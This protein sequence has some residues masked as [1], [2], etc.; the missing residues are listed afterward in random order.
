MSVASFSGG[1]AL[2]L[3]VAGGVWFAKAQDNQISSGPD[4]AWALPDY[5]YYEW[6]H[7][8]PQS[9]FVSASLIGNDMAYPVNTWDIKCYHAENICH[10]ADVEEI[11]RDQLGG[12]TTNDWPIATWT[13]HIIIAQTD[14]S[15]TT[16]CGRATITVNRD[17]KT[18]SYTFV[19]MNTDKDY[20]KHFNKHP[21]TND[22]RFGT[23]KKPWDKTKT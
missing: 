14:P 6:P 19:P 23:A 11:G 20:C 12:I 5:Q 2:G 8:D 9:V 16:S 1:L 13:D 3:I 10:T 22:W 18:V 17:A 15:D 21:Q 4:R 7:D